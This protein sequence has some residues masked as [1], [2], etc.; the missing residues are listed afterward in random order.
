MH[1]LYDVELGWLG[2]K[3]CDDQRVEFVGED[4]VLFGGEVVIECVF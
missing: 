2:A 4:D 3:C 1:C